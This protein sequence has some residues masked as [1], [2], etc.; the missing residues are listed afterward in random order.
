VAR[1]LDHAK[2]QPTVIQRSVA[3]FTGVLSAFADNVTT[4]IF[5][6]PMAGQMA[7]RTGVRP[8]VYL[9]PM[10]MAANIGGTATLI[11]DPPTS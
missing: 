8:V 3:W 5:V 11:G 4:V 2:G 1:I 7:L 6:T 10:V 9:L